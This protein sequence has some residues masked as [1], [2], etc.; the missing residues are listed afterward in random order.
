MRA[1]EF[2]KRYRAARNY[3]ICLERVM[4]EEYRETIV[5]A[6]GIHGQQGSQDAPL[7]VKVQ[8]A[9]QGDA[10]ARC[11]AQAVDQQRRALERLAQAKADCEA[12]LGEILEVIALIPDIDQRALLTARY[13]HG[14]S[15]RCIQLQMGRSER[16]VFR[17]HDAALAEAEKILQKMQKWQ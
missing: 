9:P 6:Q 3:R 2:F 17:L 7:G 10:M 15:F 16:N 4:R 12:V 1:K 13:V 11:V 14:D 5:R 8:S